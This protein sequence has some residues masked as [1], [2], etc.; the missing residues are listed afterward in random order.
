MMLDNV[1]DAGFKRRLDAKV[2]GGWQVLHGVLAYGQECIMQ[3]ERGNRLAVDYLLQGGKLAGFDPLPG[4]LLGDSKLLDGPK[5]RG[6][7]FELD[8][9][10]MTGQGHRD[11]WLAVL[12]QAGV[13]RERE[14]QIGADVYLMDDVVNQAAWDVPRNV[15]QEYSWTLIGL[16]GYRGTDFAWKAR[17]GRNW[18]IE[19]MVESETNATLEMA[20]C[21]GTHRLIGLTFALNRLIDEGRNITGVWAEAEHL[22]RNSIDKCREFQNGDG[23]F[24]T[25]YLHR[26]GWSPDLSDVLRT[27]GHVLEFLALAGDEKLLAERWVESAAWRLCEALQA[28]APLDLECGALYHALHGV[29][30]Y[31]NRRF[32]GQPWSAP[33]DRV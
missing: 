18:T 9:G 7:R 28:T 17:D 10:S 29:V 15:E 22:I 4:D 24:S 12:Y 32:A 31:R 26:Y 14:L 25:T 27:T 1:L 2:N 16:T 11:Q 8:P 6:V 5:R 30:L 21:G 23:S 33:S 3:T 20:A 19:M 13:T